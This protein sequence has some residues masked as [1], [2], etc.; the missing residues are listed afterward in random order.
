MPDFV[1]QRL[2]M[3]DAQ[4]R[5]NDV[6][7]T[8]IHGAMVE[9]PRERFVPAA[10]R[11]LAYADV[12]VEVAQ[13]RY[14]IEPRAFAKLVQLAD[15]KPTDKILDIGTATGYSAAIL[16]KLGRSVIALEQDADLVRAAQD[17]LRASANVTLVQGSLVEGSKPNAPFNVI[18]INGAV[19]S[20][21]ESLTCQLAE[22][23]RLV[24]VVQSE[25]RPGKAHLYVR[26][27][28]RVA[29]RPDFDAQVP[30]LSGFRKAI[31]FVF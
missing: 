6:I 19:E 11:A 14:L 1:A 2:N 8:R 4:V 21:P 17:L 10:K 26:E 9:I 22:G 12:S 27:Q 31:G 5:T 30:L 20:V 29:G 23:G 3:V 24:A 28:G 25:G 16:G 7:D 18:L 15:I 13:G